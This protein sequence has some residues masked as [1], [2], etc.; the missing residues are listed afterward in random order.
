MMVRLMVVR[1][2]S[3]SSHVPAAGVTY[4]VQ[5]IGAFMC[6]ARGGGAVAFHCGAALVV[7]RA[8]DQASALRACQR[9]F[10]IRPS[11]ACRFPRLARFAL[12]RLCLALLLG[13]AWV[14]LRLWLHRRTACFRPSADAAAGSVLA[15][16]GPPIFTRACSALPGSA[17]DC[18][19]ARATGRHAAAH[20]ARAAMCLCEGKSAACRDGQ[21]RDP[22][23]QCASDISS[24]D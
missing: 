5:R 6:A 11:M 15:R 17:G 1:C 21:S 2:R 8:V 13:G 10:R 24:F 22:G 7:L 9:A 3:E 18:S 19:P 4:A 14:L 20:R 16:T 12:R 23:Q